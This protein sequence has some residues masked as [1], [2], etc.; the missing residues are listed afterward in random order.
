MVATRSGYKKFVLFGMPQPRNKG[1]VR[2]GIFF[3]AIGGPRF[4]ALPLI[5]L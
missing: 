4:G 3:W 5:F 1:E 2:L